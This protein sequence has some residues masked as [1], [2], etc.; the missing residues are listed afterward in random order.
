MI[1]NHIHDALAQVKKMQ[2]LVLEKRNFRG[3]SGTARILGGCIALAGAIVLSSQGVP[4]SDLVHLAG[5]GGVLLLSLILNYGALAIW[6][7]FDPE[8]SRNLLKLMPAVDAIPA[9]ATGAALV[10]AIVLRGQYDLLFGTC[11]SMYGLAHVTY[12]HSLPQ[13]NYVVGIFYLLSGAYCLLDPNIS[14]TDPWPMG[15]V[16]FAG[17]LAGGVVLYRNRLKEIG[18][19]R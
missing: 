3:Y 2:E 11:M 10:V 5:W 14:F 17:E 13:A 4:Q 15:L 12:R 16:F 19:V 9:L 6:F 1:A 8:A 18:A 7:F